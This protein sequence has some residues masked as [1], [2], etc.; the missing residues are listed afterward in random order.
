M[1]HYFLLAGALACCV[2]TVLAQADPERPTYVASAHSDSAYLHTLS[3]FA[4]TSREEVVR[5]RA[6]GTLLLRSRSAPQRA[7]AADSLAVSLERVLAV[8]SA[9]LLVDVP[10]VSAIADPAGAWQL[11]TWQHFVDDSTYVYGGRLYRPGGEPA[12]V[13]LRDSAQALGLEGEFEL[14]PDQWYGA[15]YY[16]VKAF[17]TARGKEAWVLFGFDADGFYH[18]R[19]V[20]DVLTFSRGGAPLFGAEVFRGREGQPTA[21]ASRLILEYRAD[22]RVG[23]RYDEALGGIVHDRLVTGPPVVRGAPPSHIPDGSYDGYTLDASAGVWTYREEYFDRV[24]SATAPRPAPVL[25]SGS[26]DGARDLFGRPRKARR[27]SKPV[28]G[29]PR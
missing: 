12:V 21:T 27:T 4:K 10:G 25:D 15:L 26:D 3:A 28:G 6:A 16:G 13:A 5:L 29:A 1:R 8:D 9:Q 11:Y 24:T 20:A 18:R 23:L 2:C 19:K 22:A 7:R 14:R 17:T